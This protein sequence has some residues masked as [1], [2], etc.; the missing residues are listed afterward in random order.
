MLDLSQ[1]EELLGRKDQR[2]ICDNLNDPRSYE[3]LIEH[4]TEDGLSEM[5]LKKITAQY[6]DDVQ[7]HEFY[8]RFGSIRL[9]CDTKGDTSGYYIAHPDEWSTLKEEFLDWLEIL[10][11]EEKTEV[12]PGWID[13]FIAIGELPNSGVYH[14]MP[15]TG[16]DRGK[17]FEFD[18]DGFEIGEFAQSL[19][20]YIKFIADPNEVVKTLGSY[21]S[22]RDGETDVQWF[23]KKYVYRQ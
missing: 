17:I 1:L 15:L 9:Y 5:Q 18:H 6:G 20:E 4:E 10:D 13:N 11:E 16:S 21:T 22:Y 12:L 2:F 23:P 14:L 7:L 3:A 8:S 19:S